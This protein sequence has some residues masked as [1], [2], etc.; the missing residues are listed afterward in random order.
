M[1][2]TLRKIIARWWLRRKLAA[3]GL[4]SEEADRLIDYILAT[5]KKVTVEGGHVVFHPK[6]R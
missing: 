5:D 1:F 2:V 4:V 6:G 3:C